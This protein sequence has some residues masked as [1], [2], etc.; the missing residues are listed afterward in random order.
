MNEKRSEMEENK[1]FDNRD[2]ITGCYRVAEQLV[3]R[4]LKIISA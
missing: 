2:D 4:A 3:E 1:S